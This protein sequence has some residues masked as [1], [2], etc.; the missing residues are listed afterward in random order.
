MLLSADGRWRRQWNWRDV[1]AYL[2]LISTANR[3][4]PTALQPTTMVHFFGSFI[5]RS[6]YKCM[7]PTTAPGVGANAP[8]A[9]QN[10]CDTKRNVNINKFAVHFCWIVRTAFESNT[11]AFLFVSW[12]RLSSANTRQPKHQQFMTIIYPEHTR[13]IYDWRDKC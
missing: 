8:F 2:A 6:N 13:T 11:D 10:A 1:S 12:A 9:M 7:E 3:Q 4:L 5:S